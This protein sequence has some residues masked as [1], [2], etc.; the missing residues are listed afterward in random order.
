MLDNQSGADPDQQGTTAWKDEFGLSLSS[1]VS[2]PNF[3]FVTGGSVGTPQFTIL[4]PRTM[5][6]VSVE[7]GFADYA[8]LEQ[9]AR[10][11]AVD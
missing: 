6:V 4:T 8:A 7:A 3:S 1:V 5:E 2:D 9:M 11:N 10:D